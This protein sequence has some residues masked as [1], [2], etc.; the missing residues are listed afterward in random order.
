MN[1]N[2][3]RL[4][5]I[6]GSF[7][8]T[9]IHELIYT[10]SLYPHDAFSPSRYLQ[11]AVHACRHP[12]IVDYIFHTLKVAVPGIIT[13]IV[14]GL[15]LIFYDEENGVLLER[16][17]FEFDLKD[18]SFAFLG[19]EDD[20]PNPNNS[21]SSNNGIDNSGIGN[22]GIGNSSKR[23]ANSSNMQAMQQKDDIIANK[24]QELERSLRD[25]MLSII[26]LEGTQLGR[27]RG[28]TNFTGTTTFKLC[29]HTKH[30]QNQGNGNGNGNDHQIM[31]G[32]L[33]HN[34]DNGSKNDNHT[35]NDESC[36]ELN[37]ALESE[38]WFRSDAAHC[39][40][41]SARKERESTKANNRGGNDDIYDMHVD[42]NE[43][44]DDNVGC[45]TRPL[46]SLHSPSCGIKMQVL[47]EFSSD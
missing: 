23:G 39:Q 41:S 9:A 11:I 14:D 18:V 25:V 47:M 30:S 36:P 38:A 32:V 8:E 34:S 6:I 12:D 1:T 29:L 28:K 40:L 10:R 20:H 4:T 13:G 21:R 24:I 17:G 35:E 31:N 22:S 15:Y 44:V 27:K 7:L 3:P 2:K 16:Y 37:Q 45:I 42:V 26:S 43:D 5:T 19:M 33:N 46:K